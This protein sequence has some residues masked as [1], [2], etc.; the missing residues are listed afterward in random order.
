[1]LAPNIRCEYNHMSNE[2][3]FVKLFLNHTV[4]YLCSFVQS[5]TVLIVK[6]FFS[7]L[8]SHLHYFTWPGI[9]QKH[10]R[11]PLFSS[12]SPKDCMK[13]LF[14]PRLCFLSYSRNDYILME[15]SYSKEVI[16]LGLLGR[17]LALHCV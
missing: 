13:V 5:D 6:S 4:Q 15:A 1:M 8:F 10:D 9:G 12:C 11:R 14:L 7:G 3:L 2:K 16:L 17:A